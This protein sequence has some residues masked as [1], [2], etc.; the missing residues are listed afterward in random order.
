MVINEGKTK[1]MAI[2]GTGDERQSIDIQG[3][4]IDHCRSY[5]YLGAVFTSDGSTKSAIE[6]YCHQKLNSFHKLSISLKTNC[7]MPFGAKCKVVEACFNAAI[8]YGCESCVGVSCQVMEKLYIGA[9]KHLLG[10]RKTTANDLCLVELGLP[11]LRALVKQRQCD[12]FRKMNAERQ[13]FYDDPFCFAMELTR[14]S[15]RTL[16]R[17]IED[18][19]VSNDQVADSLVTLNDKVRNSSCTKFVTYREINPRL[20][21]H[22]VYD[23]RMNV[24][25]I[26]E[27]F[28]LAFTRMR[29]SS[30]N[31]KIE[32]GR[33]TREPRG[34]CV[35]ACGQIQDEKHVIQ[36]CPLTEHYRYFHPSTVIF[37][38]FLNNATTE[39][40]F[41]LIHDV[42]NVY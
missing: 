5:V 29:L 10:V 31:L 34:R 27:T 42:L 37:P 25:F 22:E 1:F 2:N 26:N 16:S 21:V 32:T 6:E 9:L 33:W 40:D 24:N 12:F 35:Y 8:L 18:I 7:D 41:Q 20:S 23:R 39:R 15:N 28:R 19:L 3:V 30:H 14:H 17:Y 38:D 36:F 13:G 4:I 11:P